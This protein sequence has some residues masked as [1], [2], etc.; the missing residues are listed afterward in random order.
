MKVL[1]LCLLSALLFGCGS[2]SEAPQGLPDQIVNTSN[3]SVLHYNNS[4]QVRVYK[5][6][7]Q[8]YSGR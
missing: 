4:D 6:V 1:I 3:G 7:Q 2:G 8:Q 5:A